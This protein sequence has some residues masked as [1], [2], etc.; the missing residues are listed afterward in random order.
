M[1]RGLLV[2]SSLLFVFAACSS[3]SSSAPVTGD[4]SGSDAGSTTSDAG[5]NEDSGAVADSGGPVD[6][7]ASCASSF[8]QAIGSVGFARFDGTVVAVV[9]PNDQACAEPN[10]THLVVQIMAS[11]AVYRMVIDV[12]DNAAKGTIHTSTIRHALVGDAWSDGWHTLNLDYVTDLAQSSSS[13]TSSTTDDAVKATTDALELGAKVSIYATAQGEADSAHLVHRNKT[14]QD[15]AIV[16]DPDGA[17]PTWLL[18]AFS[19]QS[20]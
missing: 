9:P 12:D 3:S 5:S 1:R 11:G 15:G 8:G 19:N 7:S 20:F 13:F 14:N 10:S 17:S 4:G 18:Y 6:K 16:I 2:S